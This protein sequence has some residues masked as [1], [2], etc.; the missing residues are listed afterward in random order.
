MLVAPFGVAQRAP[1]LRRDGEIPQRTAGSGHGEVDQRHDTSIAEDHV[2]RVQIVVADHRPAPWVRPLRRPI[3]G[4]A[5]K[6]RRRLMEPPEQPAEIPS[7]LGPS[8][9]MPDRAAAARP[10]RSTSVPHDPGRPCRDGGARHRTRRTRDGGAGRGRPLETIRPHGGPC[11]RRGRARSGGPC[12]RPVS[13][14]ASCPYRDGTGP[15]PPL[16]TAGSEGSPG[17]TS[18]DGPLALRARAS[19][20]A[21]ASHRQNWQLPGAGWSIRLAKPAGTSDVTNTSV[22]TVPSLRTRWMSPPSSTNPDPAPTTC[23]VQV[24]SSPR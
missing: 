19:G 3:R 6:R 21:G 24:R 17:S 7:S 14:R 16:A 9:P 23:A 18:P 13:A 15:R 20:R 22:S 2:L 12:F 11:H 10:R 4:D 5:A 8:S 1:D